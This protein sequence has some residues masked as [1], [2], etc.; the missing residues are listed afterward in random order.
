LIGSGFQRFFNKDGRYAERFEPVYGYRM[1]RRFW[2]EVHFR[3]FDLAD[4]RR[5]C[6]QRRLKLFAGKTVQDV[7]C[8]NVIIIHTD[9][10]TC[11]YSLLFLHNLYKSFLDFIIK[12]LTMNQSKARKAESALRRNIVSGSSVVRNMNKLKTSEL[13][14]IYAY[15]EAIIETVREPLIILD[16]SL[17]V[18]TANR[19]FFK[20]FETT[21]KE[22]YGKY[23]YDLNGGE[24]N[25]PELKRL[26][27]KIIPKNTHFNDYEVKHGFER[28]GPRIMLLNARRIVLEGNKTRLIL[29][30]IEDVT[31]RRKLEQQKEDF[32]NM[33]S[34]ELKTPLTSLK[35]YLQ[36]LERRLGEGA[37][38]KNTHFLLR[39][40]RQ[41]EKMVSIIQNILV[42]GRM[43]EKGAGL[44]RK[45]FDLEKLVRH[46]VGDFRFTTDSHKIMLKGKVNREITGD[47]ERF[48]P[49]LINFLTNAIKYSPQGK[50]IVVGMKEDRSS[51]RISVKDN[52]I[53]VP[54]ESQA[55]IFDRFYRVKDNDK[56]KDAG[57][58]L[59]L[60][61]SS[62]II[63]Q[64]GGKVG[65]TSN[66]GNGSL[67]WFSLPLT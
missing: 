49:V 10:H 54:K 24:W 14:E 43:N 40:N 4:D 18:K 2:L 44:V 45:K 37:D 50:E 31:E 5:Y 66:K 61:I 48:G 46:I 63:K 25:I 58:G 36:I 47:R 17:H 12:R 22:T 9:I 55:L 26:L 7:C 27:E 30:A 3:F 29:L 39:I 13:I 16:K 67:F 23:V 35:A 1:L 42:S 21:K 60:Y 56:K 64:H 28:I 19:A 59:G 20:T 41:V 65:V 38:S 34:H 32:L 6:F 8:H 62:M 33:A 53:G 52:G 15:S 57:F 11:P 51:V